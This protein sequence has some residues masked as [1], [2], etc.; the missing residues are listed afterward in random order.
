MKTLTLLISAFV[1]AGVYSTAPGGNIRKVI[2]AAGKR[3]DV[4]EAVMNEI[5]GKVKT[6]KAGT[7]KRLIAPTYLG[8]AASGT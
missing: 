8:T 3:V 1:L 7:A 2:P 4:P 5:Y 6:P